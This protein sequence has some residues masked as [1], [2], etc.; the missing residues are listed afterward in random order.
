MSQIWVLLKCMHMH[1]QSCTAEY[2]KTSNFRCFKISV[3][4]T[5]QVSGV[6]QNGISVSGACQVSGVIQNEASSFPFTCGACSAS[7]VFHKITNL[8]EHK[9]S[10]V[11][12]TLGETFPV[13]IL[14]CE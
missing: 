4:G 9:N 14:H 1:M 8:R 10:A 11:L 13:K 3:S 5:C 2:C 12:H 7:G 6:I